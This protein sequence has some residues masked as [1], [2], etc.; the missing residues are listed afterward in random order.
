M[1]V[2]FCCHVFDVSC[3]MRQK[4]AITGKNCSFKHYDVFQSK[5][6]FDLKEEDWKSVFEELLT[7]IRLIVVVKFPSVVEGVAVNKFVDKILNF[8]PKLLLLICM[9]ET[10]KL[11]RKVSAYDLIWE[12]SELI[13]CKSGVPG[14]MIHRT[15]EPALLYLWSRCDWTKCHNITA[16]G[17]R[18]ISNEQ[19]DT[20]MEVETNYSPDSA[21]QISVHDKTREME[22]LKEVILEEPVNSPVPVQNLQVSRDLKCD[23]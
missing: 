6:D 21:N 18:H 8:K 13:S 3:M 23:G 15:S 19:K 12:D 20:N 5:G 10:E 11:I 14:S 16:L 17:C 7:G 2:N 9:R 4:L 22:D 1:V